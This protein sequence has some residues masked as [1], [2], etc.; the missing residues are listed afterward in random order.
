MSASL[1]PWLFFHTD[2]RDSGSTV[3]FAHDQKEARHIGRSTWPGDADILAERVRLAP[4][5][6]AAFAR[7][8]GA[9]AVTYYEGDHE[10]WDAALAALQQPA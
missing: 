10:T 7:E 2:P 1:R 5:E 6:F 4:P 3:V 9:H 8:K